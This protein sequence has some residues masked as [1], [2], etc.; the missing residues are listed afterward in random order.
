[1]REA[2]CKK[3]RLLSGL[4]KVEHCRRTLVQERVVTSGE[5]VVSGY[6]RR[7]CLRRLK[8]F[9]ATRSSRFLGL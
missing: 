1:M 5:F 2:K 6:T 8:K 7:N 4:G 3:N 9:Y